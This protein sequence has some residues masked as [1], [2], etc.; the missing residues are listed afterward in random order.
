M[1]TVDEIQEKERMIRKHEAPILQERTTE[2]IRLY[3]SK[4]SIVNQKLKILDKLRQMNER[5]I[6]CMDEWNGLFFDL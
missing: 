3:N 2:G 1:L 4:I 5:G 6:R